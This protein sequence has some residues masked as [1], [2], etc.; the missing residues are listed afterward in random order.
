[1]R[2]TVVDLHNHSCLSPCASLDMSPRTMAALARERGIQV[3]GLTDLHGALES[4]TTS[5]GA[6]ALAS[7]FAADRAAVR[8]TVTVS[9]GDNVGASPPASALL[10]DVPTIEALNLMGLDV[11]TFGNHEHD[12]SLVDLRALM[13]HSDFD[14][15]VSNYSSLRP[16]TT[17]TKTTQPFTIV[18]RGGMR[19]GVVGMNTEQ[20][21]E[22]ALG[23]DT[24][25]RYGTAVLAVSPW[26]KRVQQQVDA[27]PLQAVEQKSRLFIP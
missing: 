19:I 27:A 15:V 2:S 7:A 4:T 16:L 10:A 24:N 5:I 12:R 18:D 17:K 6:A 22:L 23:A 25:L 8:A 13:A 11:S 9:S 21:A 3:L 14:W 20:T 26:T 1:M